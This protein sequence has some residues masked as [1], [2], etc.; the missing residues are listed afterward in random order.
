VAKDSVV[1]CIS[2]DAGLQAGSSSLSAELPGSLYRLLESV[3]AMHVVCVVGSA[4]RHISA[5]VSACTNQHRVLQQ[6][7][8]SNGQARGH[9]WC[10]QAR[11]ECAAA[12]LPIVGN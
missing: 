9:A 2:V 7:L 11:L 5:Y 6:C 3:C 12:G 8:V 10:L 4:Y 1:P